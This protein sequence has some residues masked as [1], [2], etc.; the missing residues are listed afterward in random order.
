MDINRIEITGAV[1]GDVAHGQKANG[2][3][4]V[5]FS[6]RT[7][8]R[9]KDKSSG[10]EKARDVYHRVVAFDRKAEDAARLRDGAKVHVIGRVDVKKWTDNAGAERVTHEI[11]AEHVFPLLQEAA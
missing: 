8:M 9:W 1:V 5:N 11:V 2:A 6:V 10:T 7:T 4:V 3:A